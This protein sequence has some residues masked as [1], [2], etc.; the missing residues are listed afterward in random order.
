MSTFYAD[1]PLPTYTQQ[2]QKQVRDLPHCAKS[3]IQDMFPIVHWLPK[4]NWI[5]FSGDLIAAITVGT[6]VIPQSLAYATI[7][8]LPPVYGIYT[9]FVGII[10]YPLFGT[11]KD[12]SIGASAIVSLLMGQIVASFTASPQFIAGE[13]TY[14]EACT[15]LALFSGIILLGLGVLRLGS[16]FHFISQPAITGFMAGSG[17]TV[18]I[19]QFSKVFGITGINTTEAPYLIFGKTLIALNRTTVDAA[20]GLTSLAYL[21]AIKYLSLALLKRYPQYSRFIF[22]FS[23]SRS[24]VVIVFSAL[25]CFMINHFGQFETSPFHIMGHIPPGFRE[26]A[27]PKIKSDML[28]YLSTDLI[29]L[30]VLIVMEHGAISTSLGKVADYRVNM[31]QEVFVAGLA[32]VFGSFFGAYPCTGA[33]S[34]TAVMSK[35]GTRTPLTSFFVGLIIILA[36]YLFMPAFTYIPSAS[37]AA[38]IVH[39]VSDLIAGPKVWKRFWD[40]H[41]TELLV[42]ALSYV[43]A[44]FTRIDVSVYVPVVVSLVVQLY[45]VAKPKH[46]FLGLIHGQWLPMNHPGW[47][48]HVTEDQ[49]LICFQPQENIVFENASYLFQQLTDQVKY[50]TRQGQP[51]SEKV[52]D[53]PW[54]F[55]ESKDDSNPVLEACLIDTIGAVERYVG[56]PV[57]WY[58]VPGYSSTV[59]KCLLF[60]GLATQRRHAHGFHSD[61]VKDTKSERI[62][63]SGVQYA[64]PYFFVSVT[65]AIQTALQE[66]GRINLRAST[67]S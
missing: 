11:S 67:V 51:L 50:T 54:N 10:I 33:F 27:V 5:W 22:Y 18:I 66:K 61:L 62:E 64:S 56:H 38:V 49:S 32:N 46:A 26:M 9:S 37:L 34:R 59:H 30:V 1:I 45:R 39:A 6:L 20:F 57:P 24:I 21:Y 12:V 41:P 52:G 25:I 8:N 63:C 44:L 14:N 42:F 31:N 53:R 58:I 4:Y 40:V 36:V 19:N 65:E 43:I 2:A 7:A 48:D 17:L 16:L 60:T 15:L 23:S 35:S 13:W 29:G 3:Y 28:S 47:K 55:E